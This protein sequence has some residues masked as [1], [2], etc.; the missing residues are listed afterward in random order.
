[1]KMPERITTRWLGTLTDA[2]LQ[3]AERE[4]RTSFT[5]L[6]TAERSK[7]GDDYALMRGPEPLI[8]A[9]L[10]WSMASNAARGRGLATW[11]RH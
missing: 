8:T 9:W 11:R 10:R 7:R 2:Q 1:M 4:L 6:D 5:R 3:V